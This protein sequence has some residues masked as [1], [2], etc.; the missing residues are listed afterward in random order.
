MSLNQMQSAVRHRGTPTPWLLALLVLALAGAAIA[1][2]LWQ[3]PPPPQHAE[4]LIFGST[5]T[6]DLRGVDAARASPALAAVGQLLQR[7]QRE[8]HPWEVSDLMRLNAALAQ[9]GSYRAPPG[10]AGLL[11]RSQEAY[12]LSDGLFDPALGALIGLWGFHTS[13]YPIS[14]PLPDPAQVQMLLADKP[15]MDDIE[16]ATD[17]TVSSSAQDTP[18]E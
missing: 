16:V 8:W 2:M 10:L 6:V 4:Y 9:G 12:R 7:D 15:G 11:R 1:L 5:T 3:R 18:I 13:S 14:S 17:G